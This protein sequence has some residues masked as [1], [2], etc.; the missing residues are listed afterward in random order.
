MVA[1]ITPSTTLDQLVHNE[2]YVSHEDNESE[3]DYELDFTKMIDDIILSDYRNPSETSREFTSTPRSVAEY[4][5]SNLFNKTWLSETA[6]STAGYGSNFRLSSYVYQSPVSSASASTSVFTADLNNPSNQFAQS[7]PTKPMHPSFPN[8]FSDYNSAYHYN[9][10]NSPIANHTNDSNRSVF[11]GSSNYL[12]SFENSTNLV[13]SPH[14]IFI[15]PGSKFFIIKS[16]NEQDVKSSFLHKIWTSTELGNKRL[17]KAYKIKKPNERIFM[18]FSVNGSGK[19]S[20]VAEMKSCVRKDTDQK[21][22]DVW[23]ENTKYTGYFQIQWIFI[24]DI[25]NSFLKHLKN[26]SNDF[27]PVTISRDTQEVPYGIG[28]EMIKTFKK[29]YS[30]TSFLQCL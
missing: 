22:S 16:F 15:P 6:P 25:K 7:T 23:V 3:G 28:L 30:T 19:F 4:S 8:Y 26:P 18:F 20:G 12:N 5:K 24:K 9:S 11:I 10:N 17:N 29:T 21:Y 14:G 1:T 13:L 27:K 2:A